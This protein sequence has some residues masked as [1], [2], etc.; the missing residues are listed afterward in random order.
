MKKIAVML[1]LLGAA[2]GALAG[3]DVRFVSP[4]KFIDIGRDEA[5]QQQVLQGLEAHLKAVGDK[6]VS[7]SQTLLIEVLDVNLAGDER[8]IPSRGAML[9]V[10]R[11]ATPPSIQL[12]YTLSEA[13]IVLRSGESRLSDLGYQDGF[14]RYSGSDALR[15]EK[16]MVD[17]WFR[18]EFSLASAKAAP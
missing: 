9:R 3:V 15:Y 10:L 2:A 11:G 5:Q 12:R 18:S 4:D 6:R 1:G 16:A 17:D 14:N 8:L 13:G 7:R